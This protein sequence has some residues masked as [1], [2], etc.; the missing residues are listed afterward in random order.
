MENGIRAEGL[1]K[2]F[3]THHALRGL[4]LEVPAGRVLGLLGQNG[5]GK[6]TAVNILTTLLKPDH[7]AAW[8]GG[9]DV[10]RQPLQ[11]RRC[12]GVSGQETAVEPLLTGVENLELFGRL[13]RLSRR[14]ARGR[15]QELLE[16]FDLTEAAGRL[17]KTYSGG[18]RRRLDVAISLI[19]S[20]SILFL[21]E[22]TT[23]LDPRSRT[24]TWDLV[25]QLVSS[26]M[27]LLLTTQYLEEA[28]QLA[29]LIAVV[30]HGRVVAQGT[31]EELKGQVSDDR[32]EIVL[33]DPELLP[34]AAAI[35]SRFS[36]SR[37]VVTG[38]E[39][40]IAFTAP[41]EPGLLTRVLRAMDEAAIELVD[42]ELRRPTLDD[43]FFELTR[44]PPETEDEW[45]DLPRNAAAHGPRQH[46]RTR[47]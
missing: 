33:R 40:R 36:T 3:G 7:G 2:R 23:G 15:A 39:R 47:S 10:V 4:S 1:A 41:H 11:V 32:V 21:D 46:R 13:N 44:R 28:D 38:S 12:I 14:D 5:A 22:P 20:P 34:H 27:T 19:N 8:V 26:G 29:D 31:A 30:D 42:V 6:T 17:A 16:I 25:R 43:V 18:M 45:S 24:T 37:A 35:T 9:F